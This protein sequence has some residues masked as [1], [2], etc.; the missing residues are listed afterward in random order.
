MRV[1]NTHDLIPVNA[2]TGMRLSRNKHTVSPYTDRRFV[3]FENITLD[4]LTLMFKLIVRGSSH[5]KFLRMCNIYTY[6]DA[7]LFWWKHLDTYKHVVNLSDSTMFCI[8]DRVEFTQEDFEDDIPDTIL[9]EL[10]SMLFDLKNGGSGQCLQHK[11]RLFNALPGGYLSTRSINFNYETFITIIQQRR[12]HMLDEWVK[13]I[14]G[15]C[16]KLKMAD[17]IFNLI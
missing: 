2:L 3:D 11:R 1:Y 14:Y 8:G 12:K 7:P 9:H 13:F 6:V 4:D 17:Y 16:H 15:I 5:R 10:N